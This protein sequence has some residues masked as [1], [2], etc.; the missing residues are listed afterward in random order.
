MTRPAAGLPVRHT[1]HAAARF[2]ERFPG[3]A[4]GDSLARAVLVPRQWAY[5]RGVSLRRGDA[6]LY[7]ARLRAAYPAV[8]GD[9]HLC[10]TTVVR[11][12]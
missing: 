8:V 12:A 5:W 2:A 9:D 1:Y 7:D 10:A 4:L 6:C 11:L 3:E